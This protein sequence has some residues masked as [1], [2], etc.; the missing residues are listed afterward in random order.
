MANV[1]IIDSTDGTQSITVRPGE[2]N[3]P[4]SSNRNSDLRLYGA[5]ALQWGEGVNENLF[6]IAETF[7]CEA[8][9]LG[10]YNPPSLLDQSLGIVGAFDYDPS[11]QP[12][13]PKDAFDLGPGKG[14]NDPLE[15][16]MWYDK[17]SKSVYIYDK[18]HPGNVGGVGWKLDSGIAVGNQPSNPQLG[19]VWF[20]AINSQL[21]IYDPTNI[22]A[23]NGFVHVSEDFVRQSG[24]WMS[25]TLDMGGADSGATA[26][27]A[28]INVKDP[29]LAYDA[30][31]KQYV[32]N[33]VSSLSAHELDATVHLTVEYS[34]Y[35]S[36]LDLPTLTA[37]ETNMLVGVTSPLQAQLSGKVSKSG[38]TMD[39]NATIVLGRP[40]VSSLEAATKNYVDDAINGG[41]FMQFDPVGKGNPPQSGDTQIVGNAIQMYITNTGWVQIWPAQYSA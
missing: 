27:N 14:I 16:Q 7:S 18:Q 13:L 40:P 15:G 33:V 25:G 32:D 1:Y 35:L 3:G 26:K 19:N 5:G 24:D 29:V 12:I 10:D 21:L 34:A 41:A 8:K 30:T 2:L 28:I 20:D 38:D 36:A 39:G 6:R 37:T 4:G 31:N 22:N 17:T 11:T 9:E 23:V